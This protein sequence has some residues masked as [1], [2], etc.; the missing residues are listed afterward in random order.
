VPGCG[1]GAP[2][3]GAG[4]QLGPNR[5]PGGLV[6]PRARFGG[7]G[8]GQPLG[9]FISLIISRV[10]TKRLPLGIYMVEFQG[11]AD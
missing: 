7:R 6:G 1:R 10:N 8:G 2:P 4:S 9:Y 3:A 11:L 5:S